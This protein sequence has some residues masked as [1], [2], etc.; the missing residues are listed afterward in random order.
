[1]STYIIV[2]IFCFVIGFLIG[3]RQ[4]IKNGYRQGITEAPL[5]LR[6]KSFETGQCILCSLEKNIHRQEY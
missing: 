6:Q 1:M 5:I 3:K 4:G 2:A